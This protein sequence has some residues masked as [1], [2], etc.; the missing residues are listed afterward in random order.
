MY[1]GTITLASTEAEKGTS[2]ASVTGGTGAFIGAT[3]E[4]A[5]THNADGTYTVVMKLKKK[6]V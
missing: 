2:P 3:G 1:D 6:K 4:A 5:V